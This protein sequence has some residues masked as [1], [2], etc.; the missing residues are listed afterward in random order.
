MWQLLKSL[1]PITI[2]GFV[3]LWNA[4]C[5]IGI[6]LNQGMGSVKTFQS[7]VFMSVACAALA[8]GSLGTLNSRA[9]QSAFLRPASDMQTVRPGLIFLSMVATFLMLGSIY[10]A[11]NLL[12]H[13]T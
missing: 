5:G 11:Y 3:V 12:Q 7:A 8:A 9:L 4:L 6:W 1:K 10:T 2:V 13:H